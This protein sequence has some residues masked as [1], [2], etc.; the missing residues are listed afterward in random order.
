MKAIERWMLAIHADKDTGK[1]LKTKGSARVNPLHPALEGD[2]PWEEDQNARQED[3][4]ADGRHQVADIGRPEIDSR[5]PLPQPRFRGTRMAA[6][7]NE[8]QK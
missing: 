3:I 7:M 5:Y 2:R 8:S 6:L 4:E 1:R